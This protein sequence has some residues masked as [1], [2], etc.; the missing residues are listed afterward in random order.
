MVNQIKNQ[1]QPFD[2][3]KI[4]VIGNIVPN[5]IKIDE[6]KGYAKYLVIISDQKKEGEAEKK[7][8]FYNFIQKLDAK[9]SLK[10]GLK[11]IIENKVGKQVKITG[12]IS[13]SKAQKDGETK[14]YNNF[15]AF[16]LT[17]TSEF[18]PP[19]ATI[20]LTVVLHSALK[21]QEKDNMNADTGEVSSSKGGT[22][23]I[24][25]LEGKE[26]NITKYH[27]VYLSNYSIQNSQDFLKSIKSGEQISIK[28]RLSDNGDIKLSKDS[29]VFRGKNFESSLIE[30]PK[31]NNLDR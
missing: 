26:G 2:T 7:P 3:N 19:K 11:E 29:Q 13:Y 30:K 31:A 20:E 28:A 17:P 22:F 9:N 25:T 10:N 1:E 27:N 5:S 14:Y 6:E 4:S 18:I 24:K 12:A 8:Q 15:N 21:I 23:C 16:N